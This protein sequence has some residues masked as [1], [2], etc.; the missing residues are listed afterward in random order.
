MDK[1]DL[2][3]ILATINAAHIVTLAVLAA[4]E[5]V[6]RRIDFNEAERLAYRC[7]E[8]AL[9]KLE[10]TKWELETAYHKELAE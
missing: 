1:H 9:I 4:M 2:K 7:A 8:D 3:D 10:E 5:E 6:E